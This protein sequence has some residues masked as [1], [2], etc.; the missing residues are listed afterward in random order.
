[1]PDEILAC[2][3]CQGDARLLAQDDEGIHYHCVACGAG[4]LFDP[5]TLKITVKKGE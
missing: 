4:I 5:K 2:P 1:M 3:E